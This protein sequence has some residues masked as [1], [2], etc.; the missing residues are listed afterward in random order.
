[1]PGS[2][3]GKCSARLSSH[4]TELVG[5]MEGWHATEARFLDDHGML[6]GTGRSQSRTNVKSAHIKFDS[7]MT[8]R[9]AW[10]RSTCMSR[11]SEADFTAPSF[12]QHSHLQTRAHRSR[13][14]G[15]VSLRLPRDFN[16]RG[17][18]PEQVHTCV[19]RH[20]RRFRHQKLTAEETRIAKA[21]RSDRLTPHRMTSLVCQTCEVTG[22]GQEPCGRW[23]MELE[24]VTL[25]G[26]CRDAIAESLHSAGWKLLK[27]FVVAG[28][29]V[30]V[31]NVLA[32]VRA[33]HHDRAA[34]PLPSTR[35][36]E[37]VATRKGV[38]K[39]LD[40]DE[41]QCFDDHAC[42]LA[43]IEYCAHAVIYGGI[44]TTCGEEQDD[45]KNRR[46]RMAAT[47]NLTGGADGERLDVAYAGELSVTYKEAVEVG[48]KAARR[49]RSERRLYLVLDLDHTLLH[50]SNDPNARAALGADDA[51]CGHK[52]DWIKQSPHASDIH[53]FPILGGAVQETMYVKLRPGLA[54]FLSRL[55]KKFELHIYTMGTRAYA[56]AI[57]RIIDPTKKFFQGRIVSREDFK[58]GALNQKNLRRVFPCD[59][60]MVLIVDDRDDVWCAD[61]ASAQSTSRSSNVLGRSA[62]FKVPQEPIENL[63]QASP[64]A[65]FSGLE[66]AYDRTAQGFQ[67]ATE[68]DAGVVPPAKRVRMGDD[69]SVLDTPSE[70]A[71][72]ECLC[73][74]VRNWFASD[75]ED[76]LHLARLAEVLEECHKRYYACE[77]EDADVK[78]IMMQI[79][80]EV[81][82]GCVLAFTGVYPSDAPAESAW[83]WRAARRF[84]AL[85][86]KSLGPAVTHLVADEVRGKETAKTN[87]A[88]NSGRTFVVKTQWLESSCKNYERASEIDFA[89]FLEDVTC[90]ELDD[91]RSDMQEKRKEFAPLDDAMYV[92]S[93]PSFTGEIEESL[94]AEIIA[95]GLGE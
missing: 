45:T 43:A 34:A 29:S 21:S 19:A 18:R 92:Q 15:P 1:M 94:L 24:H 87:T 42:V 27:W 54:E 60:S 72:T 86:V 38:I 4:G 25:R 20:P 9:A 62:Q 53:T 75:K 91:Y 22:N 11:P 41:G 64:Y 26:S 8:L 49:M 67:P 2:F 68:A 80:G 16:L 17:E 10:N 3:T 69:G 56:D 35:V 23:S 81:L 71:A 31:G 77:K 7:A 88:R 79:R 66:E 47:L 82:S 39:S 83:A 95:K 6:S 5:V 32:R 89:L 58:E 13:K 46:R 52:T 14:A 63:I 48:K 37:L 93:K 76:N 12:T 36:V 28:Q 85:P 30:S 51:P 50:A 59:D 44:C 70:G 90:L 40:V 57:A 78:Q 33:Q 84:G 73:S 74:R 61:V 55:V 65:F